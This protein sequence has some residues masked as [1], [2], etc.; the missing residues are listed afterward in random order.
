[1]PAA[2]PCRTFTIRGFQ[3]RPYYG[4]GFR[5]RHANTSSLASPLDFDA[6]Q[7]SARS[8]L[9]GN[10]RLSFVPEQRI[11]AGR[12]AVLGALPR[13][14]PDP[15]IKT[16]FNAWSSASRFDPGPASCRSWTSRR[17]PFNWD[18][19]SPSN[20]PSRL[21]VL[22]VH[23]S[24]MAPSAGGQFTRASATTPRRQLAGGE[25]AVKDS[26]PRCSRAFPSSTEVPACYTSCR[27]RVAP[28][29]AR[30]RRAVIAA[31]GKLQPVTTSST[32]TTE[33]RVDART[34]PATCAGLPVITAEAALE[35]EIRWASPAPHFD[36][37]G[38][39]YTSLLR[40]FG[41][42]MDLPRDDAR[43]RPRH[44]DQHRFRCNLP[45]HL[46]VAERHK[47]RMAITVWR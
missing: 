9:I 39:A 3:S 29:I 27:C 32:S 18:R 8:P 41:V 12:D 1:M 5:E 36:G 2:S 15:S 43:R 16:S 7:I 11:L 33:G 10:H 42:A 45:R 22:A 23:P 6:R 28:G 14:A 25:Q 4:A 19:G 20:A 31:S 24:E 35:G 17:R 13:A 40:L 44:G 37:N 47:R 46:V 38:N 26:R 34:S 21:G 30:R